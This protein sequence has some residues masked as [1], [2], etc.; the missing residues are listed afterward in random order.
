MLRIHKE[1]LKLLFENIPNGFPVDARGLKCNV[2]DAAL[3]KPIRYGKQTARDSAEPP[4]LLP[5]L[6][7]RSNPRHARCD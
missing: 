7:I 1:N 2:R 4:L 3:P 5:L 6:T